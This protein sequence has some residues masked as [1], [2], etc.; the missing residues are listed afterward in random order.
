[1]NFVWSIKGTIFEIFIDFEVTKKCLAIVWQC[2]TLLFGVK[3]VANF[4][5][6]KNLAMSHDEAFDFNKKFL[7]KR[8]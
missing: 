1:M 3:H 4:E 5:N 6:S 7:K 2:K 8:P